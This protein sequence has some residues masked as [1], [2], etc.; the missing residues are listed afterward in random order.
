M[1][2]LNHGW[3]CHPIQIAFSIPIKHMLSVWAHWYAVHGHQ[4]VA[5]LNYTDP[6]WFRF[7]WSGSLVEAK[8]CHFVMVEDSILFSCIMHLYKTCTQ[9][10]CILK[11]CQL[12]YGSSLTQL[13]RPNLAQNFGDPGCLGSQNNV[14]TSWLK[15]PSYS[16]FFTHPYLTCTKCLSTL[17]CCP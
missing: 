11:C 3:G 14:N 2:S 4:V 9:C 17:I 8:W 1:M 13:Y 6:S 10:L 5:L 12:T 16:N 7:W 15:L